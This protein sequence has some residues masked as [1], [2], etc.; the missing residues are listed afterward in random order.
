MKNYKTYIALLF[1]LYNL[2]SFSQSSYYL[3]IPDSSNI[4]SVIENKENTINLI[5]S[6][7]ILTN[8]FGKYLITDFKLA[9][10]GGRDN[11]LKI[12][13]IITCDSKLI[14]EINGNFRN[15]FGR[16]EKIEAKQLLY[17]PNDLGGISSNPLMTQPE[18]FYIRAQDAW[19]ISKGD[20]VNI[21]ISEPVN[22]FQEDLF[23]KSTNLNNSNPPANSIGHGTQVAIVAGGNTDNSLGI[24]SIGFNVKILAGNYFSALIPLAEMG[25]RV[26][27][28]SWGSCNNLPLENQYGQLII[29]QVWNDG[30]VLVAA[31]GNG[32][33]SCST[34]GPTGYHYPAALNH[35]I[36]VTAVGH[37]SE[38]NDLNNGN[39][40]DVLENFN[41]GT[42]NWGVFKTTY[43]DKVDLSAPGYD[44]LSV[45]DT[46]VNQYSY[47]AGTSVAAP[48]VTGTI[49]LMFG[50]NQCLFPDEIE[51]I[52]KLT[53]IKN[54]LIAP[55]LLYTGLIGAGRLDAF[56]AVDMAKDMQ[57]PFGTVEIFNRFID[58]WDF[59]LRTNP[60]EIKLSNN[61]VIN[62]A[63][64]DF[65]AR[66]NIEI[67][68]GDYFPNNGGF[69]DLRINT[70]YSL[71]NI[72]QS[73]KYSNN[74]NKSSLFKLDV[75]L[76]PNPN[77]GNFT[78]SITEKK[79]ENLNIEIFDVLGK[80]V[81]K[82]ISN[83]VNTEISTQN[84][85]NGLYLI[86]LNSNEINEVLKFIKK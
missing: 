76:F 46:N 54:D 62:N 19:D 32:G 2:N 21:G 18:L 33:F 20:D 78:I 37:L 72:P 1:M 17:I 57:L 52:L 5:F 41:F 50:A 79:V 12:V 73:S 4:P 83:N 23:G 13:Y 51:S 80:S 29:D 70:D 85:P 59:N 77:N 47:T 24:A 45:S 35:V 30:V 55:N 67:L 36:A 49:G 60:Y 9:F 53:A 39:R 22:V 25:A 75:K 64:L 58:R 15:Y 69:V 8:L 34:I 82:T 7:S 27:N 31:A 84:L 66:N 40:K 3:E 44:I 6:K 43:N 48:L 63:T 26:I 68:S 65:S 56:K 28:M 10:P 86:K 11:L 42:N 16:N 38:I 61:I 14:D 74:E 71:C 81:Y